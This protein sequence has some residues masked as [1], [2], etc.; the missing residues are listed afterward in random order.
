MPPEMEAWNLNPWAA[1]EVPAEIYFKKLG[2]VC[3]KPIKQANW[4]ETQSGASGA[5]LRQNL[6]FSR[7]LCFAGKTFQRTA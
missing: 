1:R 5:V 7:I 2:L 3:P 4:L 6:L